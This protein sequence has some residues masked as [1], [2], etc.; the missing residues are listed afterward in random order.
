V[1]IDEHVAKTPPEATASIQALAAYLTKQAADE[2]QKVRAIYG[3]IVRNIDYDVE[4]FSTGKLGD[5][6]AEAVLVRRKAVCE[7]Y[8]RLFEAL[9]RA[10]GLEAVRVIGFSR[11]AGYAPGAPVGPEPD[12]AWSAVKVDGKW[13]LL[14]TTWA[15][16]YLDAKVGFVRKLDDYYFLTP[17][18]HFLYD[19]LPKDPN[20]QLVANPIS[21]EKFERM[22]YLRP[23]FFRNGLEVVSHPEIEILSDGDLVVTFA[24]PEEAMMRARVGDTTAFR[25]DIAPTFVQR[26]L[27]QLKLNASFPK[28]GSYTLRLY[29]KRKGQEGPYEWAADYLVRVK[30]VKGLKVFY[31]ETT[32]T[33]NEVNAILIGPMSGRLKLGSKQSF[34]LA[35]P[36]AEAV[37]VIT[38]GEWVGLS[39]NGETW[40]G[41]AAVRGDKVQV[42]ARFPHSQSYY[43]LV[44]YAVGS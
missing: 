27:G 41:E 5:Q 19:H 17:P 35:V 6:S 9:A 32:S 24:G 2:V 25:D 28:P 30:Q 37:S 43:V 22:V 26:E 10:A 31:P 3:W 21:K 14:D 38:G 23:G 40:E 4:A 11:G 13:C 1:Q 20:W 44:T 42:A 15:A 33:F 29:A 7:G 18:E 12:H 16:G 8:S 36:G 39:K 34:K